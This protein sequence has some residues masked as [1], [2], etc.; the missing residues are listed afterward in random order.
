MPSVQISVVI[1]FLLRFFVAIWNG[2]YGPS[3]GA[4]F[5]AQGLNGFASDVA[6]S[7]NFEEFS[8]GYTPYTNSLGLIYYLGVNHIFLGSL[9]SCFAW[10]WSAIFLYK[11]FILLEIDRRYVNVS[12]FLYGILPSSIFLTSVTLREP[13][14]LLFVNMAIYAA[15]RVYLTHDLLYWLL[16]FV[17][18]LAFG[19]LHGALFVFGLLLFGSTVILYSLRNSVRVSW[20]NLFFA[21]GVSGLVV[22]YGLIALGSV[23]YDLSDGLANSAEDYQK[24]V[25][26]ADG[27]TNYRD[28]SGGG[29][30]IISSV[31]AFFQYLFEP[32]PWR[33]ANISDFIVFLENVVR[34]RLIY[35]AVVYCGN[36]GFTRRRFAY[37]ML[38]LYF[39]IEF[40]WSLGTVNWGTSARHHLPSLGL[41][42]LAVF[43]SWGESHDIGNKRN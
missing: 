5:D 34:A 21:L 1:G 19:V 35:L 33:I 2:F 41:L 38:I 15:I 31:V 23:S 20:G 14:Q 27:R 13:F 22:G 43:V 29:G 30:F 25:L 37:F 12:L 6:V 40:I 17:S 7:G 32:L 16:L 36:S 39:L 18:C 8:V 3:P 11:S 10:L 28:D 26:S 42:L 24:A 4:D 9:I